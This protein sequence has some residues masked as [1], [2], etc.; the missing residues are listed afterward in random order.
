[1]GQENNAL[2]W[3]RS[4][5]DVAEPAVDVPPVVKPYVLMLYARRFGDT[6]PADAASAAIGGAPASGAQAP[7]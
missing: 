7:V 2:V 1:M 4:Q 5:C 3:E 6:V